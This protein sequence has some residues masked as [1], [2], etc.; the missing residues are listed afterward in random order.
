M[1]PSGVLHSTC[2]DSK[3]NAPMVPNRRGLSVH[4]QPHRW[5]SSVKCMPQ[6]RRVVW[7]LALALLASLLLT[8][9][10]AIVLGAEPKPQCTGWTDELHPPPT[11]RV[12]RK[13]GPNAGRVEVV[14]FWKY[15]GTVL[16]TE[17]S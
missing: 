12:L 3:P 9:P 11:V 13:Y 10:T 7:A 5:I 1:V 4:S 14:D 16:R 15:V 2:R 6:Q 17:Y 8:G